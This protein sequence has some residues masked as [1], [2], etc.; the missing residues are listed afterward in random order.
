SRSTARSTWMKGATSAARHSR[1]LQ[2]ISRCWRTGW[3]KFRPRNSGRTGPPP[4]EP[5]WCCIQLGSQYSASNLGTAPTWSKPPKKGPLASK[6]PKSREET[7][8]EGGDT[9][10][11]SRT[12]LQQ[13]T[14]QRTKCKGL[15]SKKRVP[16]GC[17]L[18]RHSELPAQGRVRSAGR[19]DT[20]PL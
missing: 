10:R 17:V 2:P 19:E 8:K 12:A 1:G 11:K 3:P 5:F 14:P 9:R 6:R 15:S 16:K 7:P 20:K 13:D 4:N 18:D